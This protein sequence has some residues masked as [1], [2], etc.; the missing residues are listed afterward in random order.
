MNIFN[1]RI[2]GTS[3]ILLSLS[4]ILLCGFLMTRLTK[5]VKLPNVS[6]YII[7]GVLIGPSV[8]DIITPEMVSG[9]KFIGDVGVAFIAFEVGRFFKIKNL[10]E[11]GLGVIVIALMESFLTCILM[12]VLMHYIFG[13]AWCFSLL[14]GAIAA[15]TAPM[16]IMTV[17]RQ[18]HAR[19]VFVN[20]LLQV[21]AINNA[22]CLIIFSIATTLVN[23]N[24]GVETS[25]GKLFLPLVYNLL[26]LV[27]GFVFG[28]ILSKLMTP[29]RSEDNRLI[30]TI[31][32]IVGLAGICAAIDISPLLS[33][34]LFG[35][36]YINLTKD[37]EL[38][39]Q[40]EKFT[41]P[42][43]SMVFVI[44]GMSLNI[45]SLKTLGVVGVAYFAIRIVGKYA[46]AYI[47]C[48]IRKTSKEVRYYLGLALIPQAGVAIGLAFLG[49]RVLTENAGNMLM[50]IILSASV[51]YE[52]V[53]P[54]C[55]K[56]AL[57]RSGTI[58]KKR[59]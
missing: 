46:G 6:G 19:G 23:V 16:G 24:T 58:S 7:A 38:Y 5:L 41:P 52:L 48:I 53:G 13:L 33:C 9:M 22:V 59:R 51:L 34:M 57:F 47:G 40:V 3:E 54:A 42:I 27:L 43:L 50:A 21:V 2:N 35:A 36:T 11:A 25:T 18:Y 29:A 8:L 20:T 12:T 1:L 14:L 37:K 55:A 44:S 39:K 56:I 31:A 26:V 32:L 28:V 15:C 10:Q 49:Q 45:K 4:V 30:L 17:I